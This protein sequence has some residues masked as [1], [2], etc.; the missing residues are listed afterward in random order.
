MGLNNFSLRAY[1]AKESE[2]LK[3]KTKGLPADEL[4][5]EN[6]IILENSL[7]VPLLID[8]NSAVTQFLINKTEGEVTTSNDPKM[9]N[10]LELAIRFGKKL[11][12]KEIDKVDGLLINLLRKDIQLMGSR[13]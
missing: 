7:E 9:I 3:A 5:I 4:S 10:N 6:S 12:L 2:I 8:P 13:K 11:V 1:L